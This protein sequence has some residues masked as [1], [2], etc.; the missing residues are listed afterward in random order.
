MWNQ[1]CQI[2]KKKKLNSGCHGLGSRKSR[3]ILVKDTNFHLQINT[4][5]GSNV[6]HDNCS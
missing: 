2:Y 5:W 1:K 3:E 4:F 6:Q